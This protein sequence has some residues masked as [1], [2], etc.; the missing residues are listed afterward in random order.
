MKD[1]NGDVLTVVDQHQLH[2]MT[3]KVARWGGK[4]IKVDGSFIEKEAMKPSGQIQFPPSSSALACN[5][6]K[7]E[8]YYC[9][10][11][12]DRSWD[13]AGIIH[14]MGHVFACKKHP[15]DCVEDDFLGWEYVLARE[16]HMLRRWTY[17]LDGYSYTHEGKY[18]DMGTVGH[19]TFQRIMNERIECAI[20]SGLI[21]G[22]RSVAIR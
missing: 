12:F 16:L 11:D 6:S 9:T 21:R 14:E 8:I 17:N 5:W 13:I 19:L 2:R 7:R 22:G 20:A 4:L 3:A 10:D 18:L 1:S 15:E